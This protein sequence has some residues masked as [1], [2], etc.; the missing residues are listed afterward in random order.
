MIHFDTFDN[1]LRISGTLALDT[2]LH[3]GGGDHQQYGTDSSV[4]KTI[5]GRPFIPGSSLKGVL[6]TYLERLGQA[7]ILEKGNY[8]DPCMYGDTMCLS[9]YNSKD[10]R[11][12]L[13]KKC[14][15]NGEDFHE[16]LAKESCVICHLF[17]NQL[18]AGKVRISDAMVTGDWQD[19]YEIRKGVGISRDTGK[20]IRGALYDFEVI[21]AG[22]NFGIEILA[23]NLT[24]LEEK[25]LLVGI[26]GLIQGR[27]LL[28]GKTARGLGH[29]HGEGWK[30][31][32]T[33]RTNVIKHLLSGN[34]LEGMEFEE[35]I[36]TIF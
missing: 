1:Q 4:V 31:S 5:D 18:R 35:Y 10:A 16:T 2:A 17:G 36:K 32:K 22:T 34:Q 27:L 20:A 25:W 26:S 15:E 30:V 28:G 21:P 7:N 11:N 19:V 8:H 3:I 29:F 23:D 9:Q 33:D 13:L 24:P 12:K 14:E 6:R